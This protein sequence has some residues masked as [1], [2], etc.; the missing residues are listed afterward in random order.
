MTALGDGE[1]VL[2]TAVKGSCGSGCVGTRP[3]SAVPR[4]ALRARHC[5]FVNRRRTS[6]MNEHP[7]GL[8]LAAIGIP[9]LLVLSGSIALSRKER[10]LPCLMQWRGPQR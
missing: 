5:E 7:T 3:V 8:L 1:W 9:A 4:N 6:K 2:L 10:S